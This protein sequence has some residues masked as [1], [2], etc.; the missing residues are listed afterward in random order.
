VIAPSGHRSEA[1]S[2]NPRH[3]Q[4]DADGEQQAADQAGD[5]TSPKIISVISV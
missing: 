5:D 1:I 3:D 4:P 2:W